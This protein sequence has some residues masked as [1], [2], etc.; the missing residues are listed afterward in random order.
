MAHTQGLFETTELTTSV[1][2]NLLRAEVSIH[3]RSELTESTCS[4]HRQSRPP[5]AD[6]EEP[7]QTH[8]LKIHLYVPYL[9]PA[10][11]LTPIS[12]TSQDSCLTSSTPAIVQCASP[13]TL[14]T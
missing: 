4:K 2:V 8:S 12:L 7:Q 11:P 5:Q 3:R 1:H 14:G 13:G 9:A 10:L 6:T